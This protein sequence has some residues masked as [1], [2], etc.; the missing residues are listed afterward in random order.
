[1]ATKKKKKTKT[2][3]EIEKV[4]ITRQLVVGETYRSSS[5]SSCGRDLTTW[6]NYVTIVRN[7]IWIESEGVC[8]N[9]IARF[10]AIRHP[11]SST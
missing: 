7:G 1:M 5:C 2:F 9:C 3:I 11:S 10:T 4:V 6:A 8:G